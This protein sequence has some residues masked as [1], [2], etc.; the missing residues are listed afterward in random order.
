MA[1][2]GVTE[3]E[4]SLEIGPERVEAMGKVR[5]AVY[6]VCSFHNIDLRKLVNEHEPSHR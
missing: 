2:I 6:P 5:E 4:A 1:V 3:P